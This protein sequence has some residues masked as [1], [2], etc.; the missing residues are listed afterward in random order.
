MTLILAT[1]MQNVVVQNEVTV[2]IYSYISDC[3]KSQNCLHSKLCITCLRGNRTSGNVIYLHE[4]EA[5]GTFITLTS[6]LFLCVG[7]VQD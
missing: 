6:S 4:V 1:K 5:G 2:I 3:F 7:R